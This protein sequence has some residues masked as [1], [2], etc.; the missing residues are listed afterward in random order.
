MRAYNNFEM[1][2]E[3]YQ[4]V[5]SQDEQEI[6]KALEKDIEIRVDRQG[7]VWTGGII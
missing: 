7:R 1:L 5:T 6:I 2:L 3:D 4:P